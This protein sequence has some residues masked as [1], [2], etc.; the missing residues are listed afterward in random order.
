[1]DSPLIKHIHTPTLYSNSG[2]SN[3]YTNFG[4]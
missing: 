3:S 1:M 4:Y 2:F